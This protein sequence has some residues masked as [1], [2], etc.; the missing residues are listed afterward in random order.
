MSSRPAARR[1]GRIAYQGGGASRPVQAVQHR[2]AEQAARR[3]GEQPGVAAADGRAEFREMF[4][5]LVDPAGL[6]D[7]DTC[8][9]TAALM[10]AAASR[11]GYKAGAKMAS[12]LAAIFA[13]MSEIAG[14]TVDDGAMGPTDIAYREIME[15]L[16]D[17]A[18]AYRA[19]EGAEPE[20]PWWRPCR[21]RRSENGE[22]EPVAE[23]EEARRRVAR[24]RSAADRCREESRAADPPGSNLSPADRQHMGSICRDVVRKHQEEIRARDVEWGHDPVFSP[25]PKP[26]EFPG[27]PNPDMSLVDVLLMMRGR[28]PDGYELVRTGDRNG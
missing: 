27:D 19:G 23:L 13:D 18:E 5:S 28:I 3:A 11:S 10:E 26:L 21:V 14:R 24:A 15:V 22:V 4:I 16:Y 17:T 7:M 25:M 8:G 2:E 12:T 1:R 20:V 6:V 9:R